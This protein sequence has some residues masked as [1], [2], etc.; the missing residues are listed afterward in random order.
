[1]RFALIL[2][3]VVILGG[4]AHAQAQK[5][6][7]PK[8]SPE[9]LAKIAAMQAA[10]PGCS[11]AFP[12]VKKGLDERPGAILIDA[13]A[14]LNQRGTDHPTTYAWRVEVVKLVHAPGQPPRDAGPPV[15][16]Q[17]Y[18]RT[19]FTVP[20][21]GDISVPFKERLQWQAKGD[22]LVRVQARELKWGVD[23]YGFDALVSTNADGSIHGPMSSFVAVVK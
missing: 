19:W 1:M 12:S 23:D 3:G 4:S 7:R 8:P 17:D 15:W 18:D 9:L 14:R 11:V 10:D 22:Y 6:H 21:H 16:S 5:A 20:A 2:I 13:V